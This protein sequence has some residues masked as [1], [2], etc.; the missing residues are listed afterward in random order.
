MALTSYDSLFRAMEGT[1]TR[2]DH[3]E[4]NHLKAL[5]ERQ[6]GEGESTMRTGCWIG[7]QS[8]LTTEHS[9]FHS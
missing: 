3:R 6:N 7:S 2:L 5:S 8:C 9:F 4:L 1:N